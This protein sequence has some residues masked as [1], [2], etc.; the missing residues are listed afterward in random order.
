[1]L[2]RACTRS[3]GIIGEAVKNLSSD[4]KERYENIEWKKMAGLRDKMIHYYFGVN[5]DIVWSV[6]QDKLPELKVN[7]A[8]ILKEIEGNE[9]NE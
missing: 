4:F 3:L 6:I 7:I 1:M 8:A 2:K 9:S 5:W